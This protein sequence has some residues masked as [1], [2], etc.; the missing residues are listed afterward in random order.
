MSAQ[1]LYDA[2]RALPAMERLRLA[3]RILDDLTGSQG[4]GLD[5][6]DHWSEEDV[7]D[8]AAFAGKHAEQSEAGENRHA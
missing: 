3:S 2:A 7:S 6:R 4:E 1:E 8:L 5:I